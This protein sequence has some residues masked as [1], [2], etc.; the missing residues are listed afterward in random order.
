MPSQKD[1]LFEI[2]GLLI[3]SIHTNIPQAQCQSWTAQLDALGASHS[4]S[5][6]Q[7]IPV[8]REE[9]PPAPS[10][11][12]SG[13][14][15]VRKRQPQCY[16][17]AFANADLVA[18]CAGEP[19]KITLSSDLA[20][21]RQ[22]TLVSEPLTLARMAAP[23]FK[24]ALSQALEAGGSRGAAS[25][26]AASLRSQPSG[27]APAFQITRLVLARAGLL[28]RGQ[29]YFPGDVSLHVVTADLRGWTNSSQVAVRSEISGD[30]RSEDDS[31][32]QPQRSFSAVLAR[33]SHHRHDAFY[34]VTL[35]PPG[36]DAVFHGPFSA[37][38]EDN[39]HEAAKLVCETFGPIQAL[40][41]TQ[42]DAVY[43]PVLAL[44]RTQ[45]RARRVEFGPPRAD[46]TKLASIIIPLY[47]DAFFLN[48]IFHLQRL[49][50]PGYEL[51]VVVDDPRLWPEVYGRIASRQSALTVRTV[52]LQCEENYGYGR[53]NNIGFKAATGDVIFLMNSDVLV[54]DIAALDEAAAAIREQQEFH[55][56]ETLIGFSL[57]FEDETIQHIGM[58]FPRSP[59]VGNLHL[60]EHPMKGQP[61]ALYRGE[62]TRE[63]P[64]V[65][66]ALIGMSASLFG[67]L[68]G[69][70]PVFERGDFED[71]DLCLRARARRARIVLHVRPGL[72]HL[73]RQ[74][75]SR[76]GDI[77]FREMVTYL[78][79]VT[80]NKRWGAS[81]SLQTPGQ[82]GAEPAAAS[83]RGTVRVRKRNPHTPAAAR[84]NLRPEA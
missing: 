62:L 42:I 65:T 48:C 31:C 83:K 68:G 22:L 64:A 55:G 57:L 3:A 13:R 19:V 37:A 60:A 41:D 15:F 32:I 50:H 47:G 36:V 45:A 8:D 35:G 44:P 53:A 67:S 38:A 78:N 20:D 26:L 16:L 29:G 63:V 17:I 82:V 12:Q 73:E 51:I 11:R 4:V 6:T 18:S 74:S 61:M 49:L 14:P 54:A 9:E 39:E 40:T 80:F 79:C 52:L 81:L 84:S 77:S 71:A 28:L 46:T 69:L 24:V 27:A 43:R 75:L 2:D 33:S 56:A 58:E 1:E 70:D 72:Y 10:L 30:L 25:V 5:G 21:G 59:L 23:G 66:G 76:T 7:W 34:I